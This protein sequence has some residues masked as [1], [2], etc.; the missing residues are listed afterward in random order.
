MH[1]IQQENSIGDYL[2]SLQSLFNQFSKNHKNRLIFRE[3]VEFFLNQITTLQEKNQL[4]MVTQSNVHDAFLLGAQLGLSFLKQKGHAFVIPHYDSGFNAFVPHFF[5][6]YKG[7]TNIVARSKLVMTLTAEVVF[8]NDEFTFNGT[9]QA[10]T[11]RYDPFGQRGF[12]KGVY[13]LSMLANGS[14]MTTFMGEE[15]LRIIEDTARGQM[16]A[17]WNSPFVNELRKKTGIRRHFKSLLSVLDIE[18]ED[19]IV[20]SGEY[21]GDFE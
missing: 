10:P 8:S 17:S 4:Q 6:G 9:H 14:F 16:N 11:H 1:A 12:V 15:E 18:V 3:E 20:E 7:M 13:G 19:T 2:Y 21:N 5:L